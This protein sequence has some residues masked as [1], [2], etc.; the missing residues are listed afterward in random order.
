MLTQEEYVNLRCT[1]VGKISKAGLKKITPSLNGFWDVI[2]YESCPANVYSAIKRQA[3]EVAAFDP[4]VLGKFIKFYDRIFDE[5]IVPI[6]EKFDYSYAAWYNHLTVP[7][8]AEINKVDKD[9]LMIKYYTMFCKREKQI[10]EDDDKMPKNRCICAPNAEYKYVMGPITYALEEFFK[11]FKGYC[12][13]KNWT[14]MEEMYNDWDR[15]GLVKSVQL[16]GSAFDRSQYTELKYVERRIY[17]WLIDG[18]KIKHVDNDVFAF[19]ALTDTVKIYARYYEDGNVVDMGYIT[20]LGTVL[21]GSCDTTFANT[22][23]MDLYNRFVAEEYLMLEPDEYALA[24]KGDDANTQFKAD[25]PDDV[26]IEAYRQVFLDSKANPK[27]FKDTHGLGQVMKYL[28]I[29]GIEDI[30]FCST[31]TFW[32]E[33]CKSFK[34]TRKLDRFLAL[35]PWSNKALGLSR[36]EQD[37]YLNDM[38]EANLFW[39]KGLPIFTELNDFLKRKCGPRKVIKGPVKKLLMIPK[40]ELHLVRNTSLKEKFL[41]DMF[42]KEAY[43][44]VDRISEKG[45]CYGDYQNY[46]L[47]KYNWDQGEIKMIQDCIANPV[48]GEIFDFGLSTMLERSKDIQMEITQH[49]N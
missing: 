6:L 8:Q 28:K 3:T 17:Q 21:S 1:D 40:E 35:T 43:S 11:N 31:E 27:N 34:I 2:Y 47:R 45:G 39:M 4:L 24:C 22:L 36:G 7:Q 16:D 44:M 42:G 19:Q 49:F 9:K 23:R 41:R 13:G 14:E 29:G 33:T 18:D 26:I 48:N 20:V 38:Y 5:E 32:S 30:D 10:V 25:V 15:K 46:L 12:G 37:H